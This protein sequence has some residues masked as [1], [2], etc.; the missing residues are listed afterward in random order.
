M[1][2]NSDAN[3][4]ILLLSSMGW[5]QWLILGVILLVIEVI[6]GT[7]YGLWVA[8]AALIVGVLTLVLPIAWPVQF[9]LFFVLS[10]ALLVL[11]HF[12]LRPLIMG[13]T[14]EDDDLNDRAKAMVG[15]RVKAIA[16]F[17]TGLGRVQVGDTQ[18]RA[19]MENGNALAGQ[20]LRVLSVKGTTLV[21]ELLS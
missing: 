7:T 8:A 20:E 18:W 21:V 19:E 6:T 1:I 10:I 3:V 12:Y 4:F 2:M 17:E 16:D 15:M 11:G 5:S 14:D 9:I 13:K